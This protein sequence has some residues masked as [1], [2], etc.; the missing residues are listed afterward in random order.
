MT[1]LAVGSYLA[2]DRAREKQ[3]SRERDELRADSNEEFPNG[4]FSKLDRSKVRIVRRK[5]AA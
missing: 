1:M 2:F 4:F 3:E 5:T